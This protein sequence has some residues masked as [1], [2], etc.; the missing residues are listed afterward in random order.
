MRTEE[1]LCRRIRQKLE[2]DESGSALVEMAISTILLMTVFLGIMQLTMACYTYNDVT[3]IA[4]ETA[5]WAIVRGSTCHTNTPNLDHCSTNAGA[6]ATDIQ[7]HAQSIATIN[8]SQCTTTNPCVS[9]SWMTA[10]Q[11]TGGQ[12]TTTTWASCSSGTCNLPGNMVT[13]TVTYPYT[14]NIPFVNRY[15]LN[16]TSTAQM[17]VSQ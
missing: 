11:T 9:V 4:R 17:P 2:R 8:W 12:Q 13:V 3:E 14:L 5:R 1:S 10:T 7:N 6:S 16:M 15:S